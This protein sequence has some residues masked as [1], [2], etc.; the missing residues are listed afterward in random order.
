[1][2]TTG[3]EPYTYQIQTAIL[4]LL[5][6]DFDELSVDTRNHEDSVFYRKGNRV[7]IGEAKLVQ[8]EWSPESLFH[9]GKNPGPVV[10]IWNRWSGEEDAIIFSSTDYKGKIDQ[11]TPIISDNE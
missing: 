1:M 6:N 4:H 8:L 3:Q 9:K 2:A 5:R 7:A 10:Q 11:G